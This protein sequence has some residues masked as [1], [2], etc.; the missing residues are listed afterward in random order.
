MTNEC[1]CHVEATGV[2]KVDSRQARVEEAPGS[3]P[4]HEGSAKD[5]TGSGAFIA[6][7]YPG[8]AALHDQRRISRHQLSGFLQ[9]YNRHTDKPIRVYRNISQGR[10]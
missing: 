8:R 6:A 7:H 1:Y 2:K 3:R 5:F 10:E 9:V 4:L